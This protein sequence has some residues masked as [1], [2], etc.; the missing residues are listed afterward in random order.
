MNKPIQQDGLEIRPVQEEDLAALYA[1]EQRCFATDRL[2]RR[3]FRHW[4]SASNREFLVA[5]LN[6]ELLGY[7]LVLI[8]RGT[9]LARLYSLAVS[10]TARGLGLGR[11]LLHALET[12]TTQRGR[13]Y[14]RLEVAEDNKAAI[15]LYESLG[16]VAFGAYADYYEDHQTALRMQKR[17]RHAPE[18]LRTNQVPWYR[19]TTPFTCGPAAA[20]MAMAALHP[21]YP[22]KRE[23]ELDIWREATTIYMTSGHGGCHPVGLGLAAH[24]RGFKAQVY[25]SRPGTP[26]I[27]GVRSNEKKAV[28]ELVHQNYLRLA[29]AS[30]VPVR[31][32]DISQADLNRWIHRGAMVLALIST[33][34]MDRKKAPHWVALT[35]ID[36]ECLY[37]NDP[38]PTDGEQT[39]MDCQSVPIAR[40]DF[41]KMSVFGRDRLR[42]VVVI[43]A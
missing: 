37:V 20:M 19:Q 25:L 31:I 6:D 39:A 13:L 3:R 28:I 4:V 14:M 32:K 36:D 35:A 41:A 23:E 22:L 40:A 33:Y 15:T 43:E 38:D 2:S 18:N 21:K 12:A 29:K 8:H 16:Y 30:K 11:R 34:R 5:T 7:G 17:I 24:K 42:T 10:D 27:E 9:R 26:F 1:L